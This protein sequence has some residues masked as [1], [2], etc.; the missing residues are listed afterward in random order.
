MAYF[1]I[2]YGAGQDGVLRQVQSVQE[3]DLAQPRWQRFNLTGNWSVKTPPLAMIEVYENVQSNGRRIVA[4]FT[5]CES[6]DEAN[7][8]IIDYFVYS[9]IWFAGAK[10][11]D[12]TSM[13][14]PVPTA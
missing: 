1:G 7:S 6:F 14:E 2:M 5:Q 10:V 13:P 12:T 8:R 9:A 4:L 3:I 11:G